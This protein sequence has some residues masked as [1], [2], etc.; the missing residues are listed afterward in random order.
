[1]THVIEL[2]FFNTILS[3]IMD[4]PH[5]VQQEL[6][7]EL[8]RRLSKAMRDHKL[9]EQVLQDVL[10]RAG[11]DAAA[12][13]VVLN[14]QEGCF[15][16]TLLLE[17]CFLGRLDCAVLL[18]QH[19]ANLHHTDTRGWN[20]LHAAC[21]CNHL[22]LVKLLVE[23]YGVDMNAADCQGSTPLH[24]SCLLKSWNVAT[25]L[26]LQN[27][28]S[29]TTCGGVNMRGRMGETALHAAARQGH[30]P[31]VQLLLAAGADILAVNNG[32]RTCAEMALKYR[33]SSHLA[34]PLQNTMNLVRACCRYQQQE[35]EEEESTTTTTH[36][37][38]RIKPALIW[39]AQENMFVHVTIP[40]TTTTTTTSNIHGT[41]TTMTIFEFACQREMPEAIVALVHKGADV[42][43]VGAQQDETTN[44][45]T[46]HWHVGLVSVLQRRNVPMV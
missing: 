5:G 29:P 32:G 6:H 41:T 19:G 15:Q 45:T 35:E 3:T 40:Y 11:G 22:E 1:M 38:K 8:Y 17:A 37:P 25:W 42:E 10:D 23:E 31:T 9:T 28:S 4:Q 30:A 13:N 12:T 36:P 7:A 39:Q 14:W 18:I 26:I 16:W 33:A 2:I 46:A 34:Q 21:H 27:I 20:V 24:V 43:F 44:R